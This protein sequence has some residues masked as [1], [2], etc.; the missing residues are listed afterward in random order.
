MAIFSETVRYDEVTTTTPYVSA[1]E[2]FV[3]P[4]GNVTLTTSN[5]LSNAVVDLHLRMY[6][7]STDT[8]G[9]K[10]PEAS[11]TGAVSTEPGGILV[12]GL[13]PSLVIRFVVTSVGSDNR[14]KVTVSLL[15]DG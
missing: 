5:Y 12:R 9:V 14:A 6:I 11:L 3:G 2:V 7:D 13:T 10:V 8:T 1:G 4:S 15:S